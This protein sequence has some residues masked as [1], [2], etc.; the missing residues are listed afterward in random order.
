MN[1]QDTKL[2]IEKLRKE[3]EIL[4]LQLEILDIEKQLGKNQEKKRKKL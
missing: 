3:D 4:R 1:R 2:L